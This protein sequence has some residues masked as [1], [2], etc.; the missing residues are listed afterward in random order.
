MTETED[1]NTHAK[2]RHIL[3]AVDD[4]E[5]AKRAVLYV[6]GFLGGVP[7]FC[8]TLLT[9]ISVPSP[10]YLK[11]DEERS[12]WIERKRSGATELLGVYRRVLLQSGFQ[13]NKVETVI[14]IRSCPSIADC[15]VEVQQ[16]LGC[17]TIVIG[18]RGISHK[19]EFLFGSTSSKIMRSGKNCTVWIVE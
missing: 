11:S 15:I 12:A 17:C 18:R 6:A 8:V 5:N 1:I 19:E 2:D 7:G 14:D 9:V 13:E 3:I 16:R 4:S 10:D